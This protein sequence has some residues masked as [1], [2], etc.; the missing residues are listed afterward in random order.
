MT[1]VLLVTRHHRHAMTSRS[2]VATGLFVFGRRRSFRPRQ[3]RRSNPGFRRGA[4]EADRKDWCSRG[5]VLTR[6]GD[7]GRAARSGIEIDGRYVG[8]SR[9]CVLLTILSAVRSYG[10][11]R[12]VLKKTLW[13]G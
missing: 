10:A 5:E 2:H 8:D 13:S 9:G 11:E 7:V 12:L 3:S 4:G 6:N 1:S